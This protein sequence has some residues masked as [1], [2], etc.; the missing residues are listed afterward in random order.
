MNETGIFFIVE[1]GPLE[2]KAKLLTYTLRKFG[3]IPEDQSL[4]AYRPRRGPKISSS[5]LEYFERHR[6]E[7][8]DERLNS[9]L[10]FFPLANKPAV[11]AHFE[12]QY[13]ARYQQLLFLDSDLF[14][15][16][17]LRLAF[18]HPSQQI[19]MRPWMEDYLYQL[20][21][22]DIRKSLL[23][24]HF[25]NLDEPTKT[26]AHA[27]AFN[28]GAI[29]TLSE[30]AIFTLWNEKLRQILHDRRS[31]KLKGLN[32][33]FLEESTLGY[34]ALSKW[35]EDGIKLL[36][37]YDNAPIRPDLQAAAKMN[38]EDVRILH[39][40]T[41][42]ELC[43]EMKRYPVIDNNID[44]WGELVSPLRNRPS[45]MRFYEIL[46]FQRHKLRISTSNDRLR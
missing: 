3:G 30:S 15:C 45:W 36:H 20:P 42:Q 19:A 41:L 10:D 1:A 24:D 35:G 29:L 9:S 37:P 44:E 43:S 34:A 33:Y 39:Y 23:E 5:T 8:I 40:H 6:V 11:A 21:D 2:N 14:I 13:G 32:F 4:Y 28:T 31:V 46:R 17:P 16:Q 26:A 18:D 38:P 22:Q 27:K 7:F 12:Q 25:P